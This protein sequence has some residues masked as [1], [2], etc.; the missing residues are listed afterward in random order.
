M[1][2]EVLLYLI[3]EIQWRKG[4]VYLRNV[5]GQWQ[6]KFPRMHSSNE[7][8]PFCEE[9]LPN[10]ISEQI[11]EVLS[12]RHYASFL[13]GR[14]HFSILEWWT[15]MADFW[16]KKPSTVSLHIMFLFRLIDLTFA[17]LL[18]A[19]AYLIWRYNRSPQWRSTSHIYF[20]FFFCGFYKYVSGNLET[21]QP[22]TA[23]ANI[24]PHLVILSVPICSKHFSTWARSHV[25]WDNWKGHKFPARHD[26]PVI[27][28]IFGGC[29]SWE[30]SENWIGCLLVQKALKKHIWDKGR[31]K[32]PGVPVLFYHRL[33][34]L[35]RSYK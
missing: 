34:Y 29:R 1:N 33:R 6:I 32:R 15:Y 23:S 18:N 17:P 12:T 13:Y 10:K 28:W 14:Q 11:L 19:W 22:G 35:L 20:T 4:F 2:L 9:T 21:R 5:D 16:P 8:S 7:V 30:I 3:L 24:L 25:S 26:V 31:Y 27:C